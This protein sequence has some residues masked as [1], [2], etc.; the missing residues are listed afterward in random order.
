MISDTRKSYK[1]YKNNSDNS[2]SIKTYTDIVYEFNK[3]LIKKVLEG[4]KITLPCRMGYLYV[5]GKKQNIKFDDNGNVVGLA[6][7]WVSTKKLR[8]AN[9]QFNNQKGLLYHLNHHTDG[10]RY[11]Y[12]WSKA[13]VCVKFKILYSLRISR[14]NKRTLSSNIKSNNYNYFVK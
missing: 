3:F 13:T 12:F 2:V 5:L 6:P 7:D 4:D 11:K 10:V 9:E 8:S 14:E 1:L